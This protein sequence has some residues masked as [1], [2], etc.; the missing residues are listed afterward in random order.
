MATYL[1]ANASRRL[2][3]SS[4]DP[5]IRRIAV[6][7]DQAVRIGPV[8]IGLD[9]LLGLIP[10][11]GDGLSALVSAFIVIKAAQDGV[12]RA[13]L[14]RMV[15][16]VAIDSLL[17]AIPFIGDLFDFIFKANMKNL[18]LY[19]QAMKGPRNTRKDWG[20]VV[21]AIAAVLLLL[22][23]PVVLGVWLLI[24]LFGQ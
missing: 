7:M 19:E 17:G 1:P 6:M 12:P 23:I 21:L 3:P 9:G 13:T 15:A 5:V 22:A 11:L 8:S 16:N 20:F 4:Q 14:A 24:R 10:G 18:T 2:P